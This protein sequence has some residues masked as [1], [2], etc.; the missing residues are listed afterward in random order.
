[1]PLSHSTTRF[2]VLLAALFTGCDSTPR[3]A[4][5]TEQPAP[6]PP[7]PATPKADP[8][9]S[10]PVQKPEWFEPLL[11]RYI[12]G[13][14]D[15]LIGISRKEPGGAIWRLDR[16]QPTDTARYYV[17]QIGHNVVDPETSSE[18]HFTTSGWVYI[19]STHQRVY[20][21]DLG[22]DSMWVWKDQ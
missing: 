15:P 10:A 14:N 2:A 21:Y 13:T 22:Q 20:Q 4:T 5:T 1:M 9:T 8:P 18:P 11:N 6:P 3:T 17:F 19:D 12:A 16:I 7:A